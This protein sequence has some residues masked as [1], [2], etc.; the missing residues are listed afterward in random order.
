MILTA[1]TTSISGT[2]AFSVY[3]ATKAAVRNFA[4]NWILDLKDRRNPRQR[5]QP[6]RYRYSGARS[7]VRRRASRAAARRTRL[8][9]LIPA[10][11]IGQP[12]EIANAVLFLASDEAS[13][14]NGVELFVDEGLAA[15]SE[16]DSPLQLGHFTRRIGVH[17]GF[18]FFRS[19]P[20]PFLVFL[21]SF[22][23]FLATVRRDHALNLPAT[24]RKSHAYENHRPA[25]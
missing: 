11:R 2:P 15:R 18:L 3:S 13:F 7:P 9:S 5:R 17:P 16:Q 21:P 14:V 20:F 8:A 6:G 4:R 25:Q 23:L 19:S 24:Q 12:E 10:G 22:L 1:S